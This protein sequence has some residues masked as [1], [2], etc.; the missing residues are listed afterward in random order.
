MEQL[1]SREKYY[2]DLFDTTNPLYG[3][4]IYGGGKYNR[5]MTPAVRAR[6]SKGLKRLNR[7]QTPEEREW[8]RIGREKFR[9]ENPDFY[10]EHFAKMRAKRKF[11]LEFREKTRQRMLG[12]K[13]KLGKPQ[14]YKTEQARLNVL[15]SVSRPKSEETKRKMAVAQKERRLNERMSRAAFLQTQ[16]LN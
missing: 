6:I 11:G 13:I 5:E 15:A 16:P 2:I 1:D 9:Q 3:Y 8:L 10:K 7:K 14:I 12:Q 4:N